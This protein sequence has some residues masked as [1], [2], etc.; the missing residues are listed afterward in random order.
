MFFTI[1]LHFLSKNLIAVFTN[2]NSIN[3]HLIFLNI[4]MLFFFDA[5]LPYQLSAYF[6]IQV[7]EGKMARL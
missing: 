5:Y 6:V 3:K 2:E 7:R 1:C 4:K